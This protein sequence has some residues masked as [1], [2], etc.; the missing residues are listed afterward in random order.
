MNAVMTSALG[1]CRCLR[2]CAAKPCMLHILRDCSLP[3][4]HVLEG[5]TRDGAGLSASAGSPYMANSIEMLRICMWSI[6]GCELDRRSKGGAQKGHNRQQ[7][8]RAP[9]RY[10]FQRRV[11]EKCS[12]IY[13]RRV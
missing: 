5:R 1:L 6:H 10:T 9:L 2:A 8:L 13:R 7:A 11:H 3:I 12:C 4:P